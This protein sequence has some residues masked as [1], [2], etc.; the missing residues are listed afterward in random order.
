MKRGLV[1]ATIASLVLAHTASGGST[2]RSAA[3]AFGPTFSTKVIALC[4]SALAEKKAEPPFPFPT[5]NPT[6]PD[7]SKLQ[8]IGRYE[9]RGVQIFRTW[10]RGMLALGPPP[11]GRKQWVALL[12]PLSAHL[13]IIIDQQAAALRRDGAA[14]TRD[15]YA[16]DKAQSEMVRA[17]NAAGVPVC[18]TA[19]G[20]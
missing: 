10:V 14:F 3:P 16:G 6:K 13:R 18:A 15:Y 12:E 8:A 20:A 2:H 4:K 7:V 9:A 5:F 1:L 11:R 17:S 19:A